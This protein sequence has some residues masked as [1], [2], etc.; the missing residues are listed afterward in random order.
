MEARVMLARKRQDCR[1]GEH[2][3]DPKQA[4]GTVPKAWQ[5]AQENNP[6]DRSDTT[7][8]LRER[9]SDRDAK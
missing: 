8:S 4:S 6:K 2:K 3:E 9:K 7:A 1:P 5:L